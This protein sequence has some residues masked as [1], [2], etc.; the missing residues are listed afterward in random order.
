[1]PATRKTFI[2][3]RRNRPGARLALLAL[4]NTYGQ[5][6]EYSGPAYKSMRVDGNKVILSFDHLGGGL[7]VAHFTMPGAGEVGSDGKLVGF[8]VAGE[9]KVFHPATALIQGDNV[10][11]WS[12]QVSKP[13]AV[14][15]GLGRI[16]RWRICR[17]G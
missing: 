13:V 8:T 5:R 7:S 12:E 3:R 11:V 10:V 17:T 9:D 6:I 1:M 14:R 15:Y 4:A 16:S 2:H